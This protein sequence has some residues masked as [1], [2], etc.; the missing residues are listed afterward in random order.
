MIPI[1]F[2]FWEGF[3]EYTPPSPY[4]CGAVRLAPSY[5][6]LTRLSP[7]YDGTTRIEECGC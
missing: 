6:G 1:F 2:F 5:E 4:L 3:S 7:A